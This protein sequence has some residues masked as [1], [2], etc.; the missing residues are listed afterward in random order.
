MTWN[1][2]ELAHETKLFS[3]IIVILFIYLF[4]DHVSYEIM[5]YD[6]RILA[7]VRNKNI[8]MLI[9]LSLRDILC[10]GKF[11]TKTIS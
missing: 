1:I 10:G 6:V 7:M 4:Y 8:K 3:I 9:S 11:L 5:N 2:F